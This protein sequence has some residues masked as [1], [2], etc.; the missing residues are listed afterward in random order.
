MRTPRRAT[1]ALLGLLIA[2]A[3]AAASPA[4]AWALFRQ[5]FDVFTVLLALGS[6]T[7]V[8]V[9]ARCAMDLR[10]A[11]LAPARSLR[12][13]EAYLDEGRPDELGELAATDGTLPARV[14]A[15]AAAQRRRGRAAMREAAEL[16]AAEECARRFRLIEPLNVI[17]NL[18]PLVGLAGT[19]WGMILAFTSLGN[20][21]GQAGP[22]DL[23]LGISK[24]LFHTLLGLCLAIPCLLAFGHYRLVVD[25]LCNRAVALAW[26]LVERIPALED[27][28]V[29]RA[30][31]ER[32]PPPGTPLRAQS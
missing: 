10:A 30:G 8:A 21:G 5:S 2:A 6:V 16:T 23:S 12:R 15:A 24:A 4:G 25:R 1:P 18:G 22:A 20:T 32:F 27:E 7:A 31:S 14:V 3:P 9:I 28:P 13:I 19:V 26:A 29:L 11:R 17:G